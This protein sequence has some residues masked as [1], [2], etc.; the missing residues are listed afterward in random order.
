M[1]GDKMPNPLA[2][3]PDEAA[4]LLGISIRKLIYLIGLKEIRSFKVGK[5]RRI[6]ADAIREF[7]ARQERAAR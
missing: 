3:R 2:Y 7:I 4:R 1:F 6:T 5:S